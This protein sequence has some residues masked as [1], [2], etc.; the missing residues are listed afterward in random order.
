MKNA[1]VVG[2]GAIG[3]IHVSAIK[4]CEYASLYGIC[5]N[6]PEKLNL[7]KKECDCAVFSDFNE[8]LKDENIDVVHICTPHYLHKDM[9][10]AALRSGKDVVLEKPLT[11]NKE[12]L[13]E[14]CELKTDKKICAMLQNRTNQS[15]VTLKNIIDNDKSIG[16]LI[17]IS[18]FLTWQRT[19]EY[20]NADEWRGKWKTEGGGLLINQ[21][22]HTLDL[23]DWLGG[24]IKSIKASIS[25]KKLGDVI[26]VEDT[27]DALL[28]M[29][30]GAGG[31]FYASNAYTNSTPPRVEL[32][33][34]N[35]TFR[36]ADERLYKITNDNVSIIEQDNNI[37]EGKQ[38]WGCGHKKVINEFYKVLSGE[39]G[40]YITLEDAIHV[41]KVLFAFYESGKN[42]S[43]KIFIEDINL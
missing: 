26:E 5:D 18:A 40:S 25:T 13:R 19:P 9:A 35:V 17:G 12:Q 2:Y 16:K 11:L 39:K 42:N 36:Y 21:A 15:V 10:V 43:N 28:E 23:V 30:N 38:Y 37:P 24:G 6:N 20:Y 32:N 3:P 7:A 41:M 29:N 4:K 31:L 14:L 8:M 27:A 34:E 1:C 33:F 22:V